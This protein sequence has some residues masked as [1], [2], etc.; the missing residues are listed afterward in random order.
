MKYFFV[1]IIL[2]FGSQSFAQIGIGTTSPHASSVLD[3]TSSTKGL[4]TPRMNTTART[5]ITGTKGLFVFDTDVNSF[6]FHNG[7]S[8]VQLEDEAGQRTNYKLI[9]S[10]SD[11]SDELTA[12]GGTSYQLTANT[13][14]EVNGTISLSF[15][16]DLNDAY[17]SGLD[18]N[19]DILTKAT[20][21][22]F[23]GS[24]GGSIRNLTLRAPGDSIFNLS[25]TGV[26]TL[27]FQNSIIVSSSTVGHISSFGVV[28]MNII[29]L[30]NNSNGIKFEDIGNV[31]LSNLAWFGN[32]AGTYETY[33]GTFGLIEKISG[34][35]SVPSGA[36][37]IDVSSNPTV[38]AG[39]IRSTP[40][41]GS[42]TYVNGYSTGSYTGYSFNSNWNIDC[43]GIKV[44]SDNTA[45]GDFY[46]TGS[47]TVGFTQSIAS[48]IAEEVQGTGTFASTNL[49]RFSST[50]GG[51]RLVYE[52]VE[53]RHFQVNASLSVRIS[54]VAGNFYAFVVAKN[55]TVITE[56]NAVVYVDNDTQIQNVAIN[57]IVDLSNRD[58]IEIY[59]Q[60]LTGVDTGTLVVFSE[61]ISVK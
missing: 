12:G 21:A 40:F 13:Y 31:L 58:Y 11:L 23:A 54:G 56:S 4:L 25:G 43:P 28:F 53:T 61:S 3:I 27:V 39:V 44:E 52:G 38:G 37:G 6:Y 7:T 41:S 20:G 60:R 10:A 59:V 32:N 15:P 36:T 22:I 49:F 19:E 55:G 45:S 14:Y 17:I 50:G 16:I 24:N 57:T 47:L 26:E 8:W 5:S 46:Y 30:V 2:F 1:L 9:K 51:N 42:G 48:G 29:Q 35:S 18:A 33:I 34:F